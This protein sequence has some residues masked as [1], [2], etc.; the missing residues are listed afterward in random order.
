MVYSPTFDV[1]TVPEIFTVTFPSTSS[2]AVA[3]GSTKL[4]PSST[5]K[6]LAPLRI[7]AGAVVSFGITTFTALSFVSLL[8]ELSIAI[9]FNIYSPAFELSTIPVTSTLISPSALSLVSTPGSLK[10][11]PCC[12]NIGF[13]PFN[14]I[15]GA[16]VST[17][18]TTLT[19]SAL[20]PALSLAL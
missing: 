10:V 2:T 5:I 3:P 14:L 11:A 20:F 13:S 15:A 8:P 12:N 6:G 19:A 9:Y 7:I 18:F 16:V 17:T 1:F 4:S